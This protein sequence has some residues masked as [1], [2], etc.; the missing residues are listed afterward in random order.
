M[1]A[2]LSN[3]ELAR[4]ARAE[5]ETEDALR[6]QEDL[7]Y[8]VV[9]ESRSVWGTGATIALLAFVATTLLFL[10][11]FFFITPKLGRK[12]D[13]EGCTVCPVGERGPEGPRGPAGVGRQGEKGEK[14]DP[15]DPGGQGPAGGTG[16]DGVC[17][18]DP[19]GVC[20]P[21]PPGPPGP[22]GESSTGSPGSPGQPGVPAPPAVNGSPGANCYDDLPCINCTVAD[23]KGGTGDKG[24]KG[25]K[26]D[27]GLCDCAANVTTGELTVTGDA[28]IQGILQ[29][30]APISPS[31]IGTNACQNFTS[32]DS[33][34]SSITVLNE[35][36]LGGP[37]ALPGLGPMTEV[38]AFGRY[39]GIGDPALAWLI[40]AFYVY[41]KD[42]I[43]AGQNLLELY[44]ASIM[45]L[46]ADGAMLLSSGG[47]VV[48]M[49]GAAAPVDI[50]AGADVLISSGAGSTDEVI[51]TGTGSVT[52]VGNSINHYA[53]T[54]VR[55]GS[56][57]LNIIAEVDNQ[58]SAPCETG[59][60]V[61]GQSVA[62]FQNLRLGGQLVKETTGGVSGYLRVGPYLEICGGFLRSSSSTLNIQT[63]PLTQRINLGA[64]LST[65]SGNQ[66]VTIDDQHG[67]NLRNQTCILDSVDN[68]VE[69]CEG[70]DFK[71]NGDLTAAQ[72]SVT[73]ITA[74]TINAVTITASGDLRGNKV[75]GTTSV[76]TGTAFLGAMTLTGSSI[77]GLSTV[78]S[79][80]V[81]FS[82]AVNCA[83]GTCT[84]DARLKKQIR[85][86]DDAESLDTIC[87]LRTATWVYEDWFCDA[88]GIE[89]GTPFSGFIAQDLKKKHPQA[90]SV[91]DE[92]HNLVDDEGR[93][94]DG[95]MVVRKEETSHLL[96][97]AVRE[98]RRMLEQE[99]TAA[100]R[101]MVGRL[102]RHASHVQGEMKAMRDKVA[103]LEERMAA[104]ESGV[105]TRL[106]LQ[107][108]DVIN[109]AE[110]VADILVQRYERELRTLRE[111]VKLLQ[112][113]EIAQQRMR[114]QKEYVERHR[115]MVYRQRSADSDKAVDMPQLYTAEELLRRRRQR[116]QQMEQ[117]RQQEQAE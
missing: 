51:L 107:D 15:G 56:S 76:T 1:S 22:P 60:L 20:P 111:S 7:M 75:F 104:L 37:D 66:P 62:V 33:T 30:S 101:D 69:T 16:A 72:L 4:L 24:D 116:R 11:L 110:E 59:S 14:G 9:S 93:T 57:N 43:I 26:G 77:S 46:T 87:S 92:E 42:T 114:E 80:T 48:V 25:D 50:T 90:V 89:R 39:V 70:N 83:G 54:K 91:L 79:T 31:C 113:G 81:T 103:R 17:I 2:E 97:G 99:G 73:N 82:G 96:V 95:I 44:S 94:V 12:V 67:L 102:A 84:S 112:D 74:T 19:M 6:A 78:T 32:C 100:A 108:A 29:C 55:M 71:V 18:V 88:K 36:Y 85:D 38:A 64:V 28:T 65:E 49:S 40:R 117:L 21:A 23:C 35:F 115:K 41:A 5:Q 27:P 45:R 63:D 34:F 61:S 53:Q 3:D 52:S 47:S 86:M 10:A 106:Q 8:N 58:Q 13:T 68:L 105:K 109:R 98:L